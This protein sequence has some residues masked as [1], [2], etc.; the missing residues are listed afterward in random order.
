M[1]ET[2]IEVHPPSDDGVEPSGQVIQG[3]V[4]ASMDSQFAKPDA[5]GLERLGAHPWQELARAATRKADPVEQARV[6][7]QLLC[8]ASEEF[9]EAITRA[10]RQGISWRELSSRTGLP[11]QTLH[12]RYTDSPAHG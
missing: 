8:V 11:H 1:V 6:L 7:A 12:R 5:F 9:S 4:G 2:A 10:R 3:Q